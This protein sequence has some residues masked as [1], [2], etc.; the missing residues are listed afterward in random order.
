MTIVLPA[1]RLP[2]ASASRSRTLS[3]SQVARQFGLRASA[4]RYYER[5]GILPPAN[6]MGGKRCYDTAMLR[7]LAVVQR[8]REVGFS[9]DEINRL[10]SG[11]QP[12]TPAS[13]RWRQLSERKVAELNAAVERIL[14]MKALLQ[15]MS[16]C[17]CDA[18]DECG[19]GLLWQMSEKP[20]S[21]SSRSTGKTDGATAKRPPRC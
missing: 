11:F 18:L 15:R 14:T 19:A 21:S 20:S 9:L 5:M 10:F 2:A 6:R 13:E 8:A 17:R 3:I 1:T 7:R 16:N 12:G 4:L